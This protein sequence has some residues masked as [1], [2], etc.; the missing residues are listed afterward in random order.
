MFDYANKIRQLR[1]QL[2]M[3]QVDLAEGICSQATVSKIEKGLV[4][5]DVHLLQK[6]SERL[7]I[8][9]IDLISP[10][11]NSQLSAMVQHVMHFIQTKAYDQLKNYQQMTQLSSFLDE[12]VTGV[13]LTEQSGLPEQAMPHF[14]KAL[15]L[16]QNDSQKV[17]LGIKVKLSM[18]S[19]Y[20]MM[21]DIDNA[22]RILQEAAKS[23]GQF[24]C[25]FETKQAVYLEL[26]KLF[27]N[28]EK[29]IEAQMYSELGLK[30]TLE[31]HSLKNLDQLYVLLATSHVKQ[32]NK[33]EAMDA[34]RK[35]KSLAEMCQNY[36]L[37]PSIHYLKQDIEK[38]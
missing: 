3:K 33:L 35:A 38:Q 26:A 30:L 31:N 16:L 15:A 25:E 36:Q 6:L 23:A 21:D 1:L 22:L 4:Q 13:L 37:L 14:E 2:N 5:P 18:A 9:L 27:L 29:H 11:S 24:P 17:E 20:V 32:V 12:W 28:E 10:E 19:A 7:N 8:S 34:L